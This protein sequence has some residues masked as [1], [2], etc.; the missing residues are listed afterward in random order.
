MQ[1]DDDVGKIATSTPVLVAKALEC[2]MEDV[3]RSAA[4]VATQRNTKTLS[5][6]HLKHCINEED[7]FD[8]LRTTVDHIPTLDDNKA[9]QPTRKKRPRSAASSSG[10]AT[11]T[12]SRKRRG[13]QDTERK[14][15][16]SGTAAEPAA[17]SSMSITVPASHE[18]DTAV[19]TAPEP[20]PTPSPPPPQFPKNRDDDEENYDDDDDDDDDEEQAENSPKKSGAVESVGGDD[21]GVA[22]TPTAKRVS[23]QALLS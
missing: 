22:P 7:Q 3:L 4:H 19:D 16:A 23:V 12:G 8:F 10:V 15:E 11:S 2:L 18:D 20:S 5:P 17:E 9:D 14:S 21:S 1:S 6:Q 13:Q